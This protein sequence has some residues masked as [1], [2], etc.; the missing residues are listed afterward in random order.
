MVGCTTTWL[1]LCAGQIS[2]KEFLY[3]VQGWVLDEDEYESSPSDEEKEE[4][5]AAKSAAADRLRASDVSN[6]RADASN[7]QFVTKSS[8]KKQQAFKPST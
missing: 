2:F 7:R 1:V 4:A 6:I 5:M 8:M 3:A